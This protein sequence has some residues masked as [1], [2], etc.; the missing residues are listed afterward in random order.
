M[1]SSI[2]EQVADFEG[3]LKDVQKL[4]INID[5]TDLDQAIQV[6]SSLICFQAFMYSFQ[7]VLRELKPFFKSKIH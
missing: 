4:H 1:I 3:R 5:K 2:F 7:I 6:L